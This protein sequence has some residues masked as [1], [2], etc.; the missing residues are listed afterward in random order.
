MKAAI[1]CRLSREDPDARGGRE[2]ESIQNQRSMLVEYALEHDYDIHKVY[3]DEAYSGADRDR[4]GFNALI[5]DAREHRFDVVLVK[6]QSRFTRD[7]ELV[8]HYI[9]GRFREW[10]IRF[11]AVVD[12]A[13]TLD[14]TNKKARQITGLINEWYLED[15][16]ENVRSVLDHK[17]RSGQYI[18]SSPLYGYQKDPT[19]KN[20]LV[21]D[22][23][24][25]RTVQRIFAMYIS[26][27][28]PH[29]IARI[30][31]TEGVPNPTKYKQLHGCTRAIPP[32]CKN[33]MLWSKSTIEKM[34]Q[35]RTYAGDLVQGRH[36]KASYKSKKTVN[37]PRAQWI[38]VP[39]THEAIIE[40]AQFE[41]VQSMMGRRAVPFSEAAGLHPLSGKL[42]CAGCG[43]VMER[44]CGPKR[45]NGKRAYYYRCRLHQ[46]HPEACTNRTAANAAMLEDMVLEKIQEHIAP[47]TSVN[48]AMLPKNGN[49][50]DH[51]AS[52]S[53][54]HR[55]T[56][57]SLI[58][59]ITIYPRSQGS[60]PIDIHWLY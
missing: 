25:A 22:A 21:V 57:V 55:D 39:G 51:D 37:L 38:T 19:D 54:L 24:A 2:A 15:L 3:V 41:A 14:R 36:R 46:Q 16:S 35:N 17:R 58:D 10:G 40:N 28:G 7:M 11:I 18:A 1:Y 53:A 50:G 52:L 29:A 23:A 6:T 45:K 4:P 34:L 30:L 27:T 33:P 44:S 26:G 8:E 43:R 13:D 56:V 49:A 32:R 60:I 31:N 20:H 59:T 12:H 9:H 5:H 47:S 42:V 48:C